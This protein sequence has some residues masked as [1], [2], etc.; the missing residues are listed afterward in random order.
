MFKATN[1]FS[2]ANRGIPCTLIRGGT[3]K[4]VFFHAADLPSNPDARNQ[5]LLN[6]MGSPH[7]RQIDGIG[8]GDPL[9]SKVAIINKSNKAG[10]DI[11]YLLCQVHI[12]KPIVE[13]TVN[14]G[15]ILSGVGPFAIEKNLIKASSSE[16]LV[17]I[18]NCNTDVVIHATVQTPN[19]FVSYAGETPIDGVPGTASPIK[20]S[21]MNPVGA[22]TGKLLPTGN[23]SDTIAGIQVSCVDVAVPMVIVSAES[24]GKTA[25]EM[26]DE[27]DTDT[28][29]RKKLESIRTAA[30]L[31]MDLGNVSSSVMPK[32]CIVSKPRYNGTIS[33]RYFTPFACHSTHAVSGGLCLAASCMIENSVANKIV[34]TIPVTTSTCHI[35]IEHPA[36][37]LSTTLLIEGHG[38]DITFPEGAFFRTA[39][40]LFDGITFVKE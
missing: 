11:D 32:I 25:Y 5:L 9:S 12:E 29:F 8:G 2:N 26:T 4:G 37:K 14:C 35:D 1:V 3:S 30:A 18:Y 33:S 15:N 16:T 38:L 23:V 17:K 10:I 22:K 6:I 20:L 21:F 39:R 36:G 19:G 27:L 40:M 34:N 31:K 24:L 28:D 7:Y 13:T